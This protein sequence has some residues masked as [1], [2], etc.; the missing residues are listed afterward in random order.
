MQP[1]NYL[2][3]HAIELQ[4][5]FSWNDEEVFKQRGYLLERDQ[6]NALKSDSDNDGLADGLE[7]KI[8]GTDPNVEDT[9]DDGLLDG[10]EID[11]GTD[12]L[13]PDTDGDGLEDG[14]EVNTYNTN[15]LKKDTD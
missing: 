6:T 10:A 13:N 8:Y 3:A 2:E 7:V 9:D 4:T 14:E 12:P 11:A 15:P 1:S 5:D